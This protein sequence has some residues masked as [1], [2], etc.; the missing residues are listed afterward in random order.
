MLTIQY[1]M[2]KEI[3]QW[4]SDAMYEGALVADSTVANHLMEMEEGKDDALVDFT[5]S[6]LFLVDTSGCEMYESLDSE[7][8]SK[9]NKGEASLVKYFVKLLLESK[10]EESQIGVVTPYNAQVKLFRKYLRED[11]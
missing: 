11:N 1:R 3:M 8:G 5:Q 2:N 9:Y 7:N 6:S 4:S 10:V